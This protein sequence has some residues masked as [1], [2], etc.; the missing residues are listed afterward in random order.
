MN[1]QTLTELKSAIEGKLA[2]YYNVSIAD[3]NKEQY[4]GALQLVVKD[5]LSGKR[6]QFKKEI[7]RQQSK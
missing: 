2:R 7:K 1:T 5:I 3:A 4:Y 6:A